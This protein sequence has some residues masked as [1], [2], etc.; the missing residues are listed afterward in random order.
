MQIFFVTHCVVNDKTQDRSTIIQRLSW[1]F[2]KLREITN[3]LLLCLF[4][5]FRMLI[6]VY[7]FVAAKK[8]HFDS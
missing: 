7:L 6:F 5:S 4:F 2:S 1:G 3:L 8:R